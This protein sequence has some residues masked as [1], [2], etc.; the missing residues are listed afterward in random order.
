[1]E[2]V[3]KDGFPP[4]RIIG[5]TNLEGGEISLPGN[6]SSQYISALLMIGPVLKKGLKLVLTD[7]I[8]SRPYINMTLSMM[9][10]FGAKA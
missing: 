4:L 5:N 8:V 2:Y 1:V 6:V 10:E 9:K 7:N 3:E